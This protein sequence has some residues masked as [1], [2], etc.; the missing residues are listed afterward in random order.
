MIHIWRPWKLSNFQDPHPPYLSTSKH[1]SPSWLWTSNFKQT[2]PSLQMITNELKENLI[3]GWLLYLIRS[4]L[5]FGSRF[6]INSLI[7]F[8]FPLTSFHSDDT[9]LSAFLWLYTFACAVVQKYHEMS[10]TYNYCF[11]VFHIFSTHF[12]INLSAIFAKLENVNKLWNNNHTVYVNEQN[13]T[14]HALHCSI[15][16]TNK[17]MISMKDGFTV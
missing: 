7:L 4:L 5:R 15:W 14:D 13:Q 2:A 10:F 9:S 11:F 3:Q 16:P 1:L 8:C 6:H 17:A 12:S